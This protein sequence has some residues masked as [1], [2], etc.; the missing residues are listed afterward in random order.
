MFAALHR[1]DVF[2]VFDYRRYEEDK[3]AMAELVQEHG[4]KVV[5][6]TDTWL[7]PAATHAEVVLPS[8]VAA[9]SPYDSLVPTLA[10][11][12]TVIAGVITALGEDAHQRMRRG[13]E[14]ARRMGLY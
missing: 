1:R 9:P 5:L 7:S 10:V 11:I 3:V 4:G 8:Q 2:V 13:E 12:E 14:T 6:F